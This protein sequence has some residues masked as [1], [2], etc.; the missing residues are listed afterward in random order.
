[1]TSGIFLSRGFAA[2]SALAICLSFVSQSNAA[3]LITEWSSIEAPPP[4]E[5][6]PV[7]LQGS[8]TALLLLDM[9]HDGC[10][11][12][13]RCVESVPLVK[14]LHDEARAAGAMVFYSLTGGE[15][16]TPADIVDPGIA[17][18]DGERAV[19]RGPDKFMDSDL[20]ERLRTHGITT[21][22]VCGTSAQGSVLGTGS[23]SAQ[24]GYAVVVPIDCVSS[25]DAFMEQYA[26]WHMYRGAPVR[27]TEKTTVSRSDMITFE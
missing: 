15:N 11:R 3:D 16:P 6:K 18:R 1:M 21:V 17:P 19:A 12:R 4:P 23:G 10:K 27:I 14:R 8:T 20:A 9:M 13:V 2:V 22:I 5:L 26:V 7:T 25:E 24:R